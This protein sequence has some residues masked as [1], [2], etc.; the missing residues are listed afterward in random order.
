MIGGPGA[1]R[2]D[3]GGNADVV[4]GGPGNDTFWAWDGTSDR[5]DGGLGHDRAWADRLDRTTGIE[6][7]G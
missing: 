3:G 4:F 6:Q 5:L 1:D 2:L 7:F